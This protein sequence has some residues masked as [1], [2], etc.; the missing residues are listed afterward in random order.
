MNGRY[1]GMLGSTE[2][3]GTLAPSALWISITWGLGDLQWIVCYRTVYDGREKAY[4]IFMGGSV[5][6]FYPDLG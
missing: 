4:E 3:S 5:G 1:R 2:S 6:A